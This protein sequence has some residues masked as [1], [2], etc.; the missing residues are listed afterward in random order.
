[1]FYFAGSQNKRKRQEP[2]R[3]IRERREG[4]VDRHDRV[5]VDGSTQYA[6]NTYVKF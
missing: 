6:K 3:D 1:M 5:V 4:K 2:M